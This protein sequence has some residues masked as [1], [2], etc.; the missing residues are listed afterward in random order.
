MLVNSRQ[1]A[2]HDDRSRLQESSRGPERA[3]APLGLEELPQPGLRSVPGLHGALPPL[4]RRPVAADPLGRTALVSPIAQALRRRQDG[5]RRRLDSVADPTADKLSH[6]AA[7][8]FRAD[9]GA[10]GPLTLGGANDPAEPAA[11]RGADRVFA[12]IRRRPAPAPEFQKGLHLATALRRSAMATGLIRR[13]LHGAKTGD[14][15]VHTDTKKVFT[16]IGTTGPPDKML[17]LKG[18]MNDEPFHVFP[19]VRTYD[20]ESD[21]PESQVGGQKKAEKPRGAPPQL[22]QGLTMPEPRP[23]R[24]RTAEDRRAEIESEAVGKYTGGV[25]QALNRYLR[26]QETDDDRHTMANDMQR[27][28]FDGLGLADLLDQALTR[29]EEYERTQSKGVNTDKDAWIDIWGAVINAYLTCLNEALAKL[30]PPTAKYTSRGVGLNVVPQFLV[31]HKEG[32]VVTDPAF[33]STAYGM[34]F[35]KDS[36]V[37][38][39]LPTEHPGRQITAQSRMGSNEAEIVFPPGSGYKV[40]RV[41]ERKVN[42]LGD[43]R[44]EYKYAKPADEHEFDHVISSLVPLGDRPR[45]AIV[46]RIFFTELSIP[47]K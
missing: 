37:V 42:S 32:E 1:T 16:V 12:A 6:V 4:R 39:K 23:R 22:P 40:L 31:K 30:P 9:D 41:I 19:D 11:D 7:Q 29:S 28:P 13:Q 38:I 18:E 2:D 44:Y 10:T 21:E 25:Y 3:S 15:A 46:E 14:K 45:F 20:L 24:I 8:R 43:N 27:F 5:D 47:K 36:L 35:S 26:G 17:T 34:P 33:M